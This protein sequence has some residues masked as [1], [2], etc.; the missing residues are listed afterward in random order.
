MIIRMV[1]LQ[2]APSYWGGQFYGTTLQVVETIEIDKE[3]NS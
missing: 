3:S 1:Y 2:Y